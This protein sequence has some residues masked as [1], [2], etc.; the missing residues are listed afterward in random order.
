MSTLCMLNMS[1]SR[2]S[3]G[4]GDAKVLQWSNLGCVVQPSADPVS[5]NSHSYVFESSGSVREKVAGG[6][7]DA[8]KEDSNKRH[9]EG[10]FRWLKAT[11]HSEP[12]M[13]GRVPAY[14]GDEFFRTRSPLLL[15]G[16]GV[17][18]S[19]LQLQSC[20]VKLG[21]AVS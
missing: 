13:R 20:G 11:I 7:E 2:S 19:R 18:L 1:E 21:D 8:G 15:L 14:L 17:K 9:F 3:R 6:Q 12:I 5:S 4:R 16:T 10:I